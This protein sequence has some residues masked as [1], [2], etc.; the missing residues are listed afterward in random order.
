MR[1][2]RLRVYAAGLVAFLLG[3]PLT[4]KAFGQADDIIRASFN[5][6]DAIID[7]AGDS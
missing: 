6:A 4:Q 5:L 1:L 7:S 2:S 3:L